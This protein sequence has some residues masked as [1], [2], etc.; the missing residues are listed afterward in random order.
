MNDE[1]RYDMNNK[2]FFVEILPY[3]LVA[4][5]LLIILLILAHYGSP[6]ILYMISGGSCVC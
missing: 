4:S 6:I 5:I 2:K 1:E 3:L